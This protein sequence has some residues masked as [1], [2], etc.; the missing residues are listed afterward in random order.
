MSAKESNRV[1]SYRHHRAS[2]QG[3]VTLAGKDHYLGKHG[4]AASRAEYRRLVGEFIANNR[5]LP[6][7]P[8]AGPL[9]VGELILRHWKYVE[10]RTTSVGVRN[11]YKAACRPL[12]RLYGHTEAAKFGPLGLK[13]VRAEM[14]KTGCSAVVVQTAGAKGID[15]A[16]PQMSRVTANKYTNAIR[17]VFKWGAAEEL[18]PAEVWAR[19][20]TVDALR[21][22]EGGAED[23]EPVGPV[24]D[25]LVAATLPRLSSVIADMVRVQ[26]L[27]GMRPSEVCTMT[28]GQIDMSGRVWLYKPVHHKNAHR[29]Q[30]RVIAIGPR[31]Q[32]ILRPYLRREL[33]KPLFSPVEAVAEVGREWTGCREGYDAQTYRQAIKNACLKA[34]LPVWKPNQLRHAAAT[35]LRKRYGLEVASAML[36]HSALN[37]TEIY[38]EK[39]LGTV[40]RIAAEVG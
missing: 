33:S 9:T 19:L 28:G 15:K 2:G 29:G 12:R 30:A 38:A 34:E 35:D 4:S 23:R 16:R 39:D 14:L 24:A 11:M 40:V 1:P 27:T 21:R 31:A 8:Q 6:P 32:D 3:I 20:K 25:A 5:Q 26:R 7:D 22:G 10:A 18:I 13:A 17:L 37:T 36:G